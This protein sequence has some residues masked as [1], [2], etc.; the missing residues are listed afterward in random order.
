MNPFPAFHGREMMR[1][2]LPYALVA[3]LAAALA[4]QFFRG[5]A[6]E[7]HSVINILLRARLLIVLCAAALI[8]LGG[9]LGWP[10][11]RELVAGSGGAFLAAVAL[12]CIAI[13]TQGNGGW[14]FVA[15]ALFVPTFFVIAFEMAFTLLREP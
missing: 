14:F 2:A 3:L 6:D 15:A 5:A 13:G 1:G 12:Y 11:R 7:V 10:S 9:W 4:P 8:A